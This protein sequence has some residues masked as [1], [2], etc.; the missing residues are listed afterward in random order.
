MYEQLEWTLRTAIRDGRLAPGARLPSS[1]A[2]AGELGISRG[3][4]TSAYAQLGHAA[5]VAVAEGIE[6][7]LA[8]GAPHG[9]K[10]AVAREAGQVG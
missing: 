8:P 9:A 4:V 5:W 10:P 7:A 6:G 2:L 3:V 1:R